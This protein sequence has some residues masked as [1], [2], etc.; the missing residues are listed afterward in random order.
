MGNGKKNVEY[1]MTNPNSQVKKALEV[2]LPG[3][4]TLEFDIGYCSKKMNIE[5]QMMKEK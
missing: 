2:R 4:S 5:W 1:L 3:H